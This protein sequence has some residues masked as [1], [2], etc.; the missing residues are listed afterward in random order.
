MEST[1]KVASHLADKGVTEPVRE[2]ASTSGR[3]NEEEKD[4]V[5][6]SYAN[7]KS[8]I[9]KEDSVRFTAHYGLEV[10]IP[11]ELERAHHPP[12]GYGTLSGTYLKFRV[13]FPLHLFFVDVL[14]Y[15]RFTVLQVTP[16][17]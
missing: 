12:E 4:E 8:A 11:Y 14:K 6:V 15:F 3:V 13:R 17:G 16:N 2:L 7:L 5:V 1:H 10:V 9:T